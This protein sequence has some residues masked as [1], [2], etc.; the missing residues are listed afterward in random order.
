MAC[1]PG[2]RTSP[3]SDGVKQLRNA[4]E[5]AEAALASALEVIKPFAVEASEKNGEYRWK[6][7]DDRELAGNMF[8][9]LTFGDFRRARS[10]LQ[11]QR[12]A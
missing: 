6:W 2:M 7:E 10:F 9:D 5:R 1:P 3:A 4:K 8:C 11:S 12:P